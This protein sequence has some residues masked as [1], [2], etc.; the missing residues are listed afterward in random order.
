M[1]KIVPPGARD[2]ENLRM[3][4]PKSVFEGQPVFIQTKAPGRIGLVPATVITAMGHTARVQCDDPELDTWFNVD[5][6]R[7]PEQDLKP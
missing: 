3:V 5:E 6:L 2:S 1:L 7:V 4:A